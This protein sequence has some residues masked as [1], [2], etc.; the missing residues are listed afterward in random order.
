M[1]PNQFTVAIEQTPNGFRASVV[2]LSGCEAF[3]N[4]LP[5]V[6]DKMKNVLEQR[7]DA[8]DSLKKAASAL[9]KS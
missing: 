2:E 4:T 7:L 6:L 5:E 1:N 3:G 8:E 9:A